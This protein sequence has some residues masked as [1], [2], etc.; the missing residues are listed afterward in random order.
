MTH[1]RRRLQNL[2][3]IFA[4]ALTASLGCDGESPTGISCAGQ[5][6]VLAGDPTYEARPESLASAPGH[7]V[8]NCGLNPRYCYYLDDVRVYTMGNGTVLDNFVNQRVL[9]VG[10]AVFPEQGPPGEL[11]AGTVCRIVFGS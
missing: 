7:L 8:K 4:V 2:T 10:K 9:I 1:I 11:W 6:N 5:T 3:V